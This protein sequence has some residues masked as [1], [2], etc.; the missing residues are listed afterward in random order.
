MWLT[1]RSHLRELRGA[2]VS[3]FFDE[4]A[5][6]L[7]PTGA[8]VATPLEGVGFPKKAFFH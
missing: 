4:D 7:E 6:A 3:C 5:S 1:C 8:T 2:G